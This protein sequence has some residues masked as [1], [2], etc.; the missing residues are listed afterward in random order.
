VIEIEVLSIEDNVSTFL[1]IVVCCFLISFHLVTMANK[2]AR[3]NMEQVHE[4]RKEDRSED[5]DSYEDDED[6]S[7]CS[8]DDSEELEALQLLSQQMQQVKATN[9][10]LKQTLLALNKKEATDNSNGAL[11]ASLLAKKNAESGDRASEKES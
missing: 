10:Q 8:S 3:T 9:Q 11:V 1:F 4:E 2:K 7:S 6:Y 5:E